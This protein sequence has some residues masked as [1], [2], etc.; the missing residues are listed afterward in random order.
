[1]KIWIFLFLSLLA[2]IGAGLGIAFHQI[3]P[4]S[5]VAQIYRDLPTDLAKLE[6][7][8][9]ESEKSDGP[10]L[11]IN[12]LTFDFGKC[13]SF[14]KGKHSFIFR[15]I[16]IEPLTLKVGPSSCKCT[17]VELGKETLGPGYRA[18]VTVSWDPKGR[19]GEFK[20]TAIIETNDPEN[21]RVE[22][23][24][25]GTVRAALVVV[26]QKLV[27]GKIFDSRSS[28]GII[29]FYG[30]EKKPLK[31]T[32][33]SLV[34]D[35]LKDFILFEHRPM[36]PKEYESVGGATSGAV[37]TV[38]I[39][40]GMKIDTFGGTISVETN[41]RPDGAIDVRFE[42][43][44]TGDISI[45]GTGWNEKLGQ[46]ILGVLSNK[47]EHKRTLSIV[48]HKPFKSIT[49]LKIAKIFP[50][51]IIK[52]ELSEP[53]S[54][55]RG[56]ALQ[57]NLDV[58]IPKGIPASNYFSKDPKKQGQIVIETGNAELG[59]IKIPVRFATE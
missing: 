34:Y 21:D 59:Q 1:M 42:G 30:Y 20:E 37:V 11:E 36:T 57:V 39:K 16:G 47:R 35:N 8:A 7:K 51:E 38:K 28:Y 53:K 12:E 56:E 32:D 4:N 10:R 41:Y 48:I 46:L 33:V 3:S 26:P 22:L 54:I 23:T 29:R 18:E 43:L 44:V 58:T 17:S 15:N 40:P 9:P 55:S 6:I 50:A 27:F 49:D 14:K 5:K 19:L 13:D 24:I 31:I 25:T 45:F 2:G 52:A